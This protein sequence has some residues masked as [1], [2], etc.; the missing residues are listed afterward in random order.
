M[1]KATANIVSK[2]RSGRLPSWRRTMEAGTPN[3]PCR[4]R[5]LPAILR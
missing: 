5:R 3:V 2:G 1:A 4:V